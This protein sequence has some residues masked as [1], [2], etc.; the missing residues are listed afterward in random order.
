VAVEAAGSVYALHGGRLLR[1]DPSGRISPVA[2]GFASPLGLAAGPDGEIYVADTGN[3]V[4]RR[5]NV[6]AGTTEI[7][8]RDLGYVVS[9]AGAPDGTIWSSSVAD[10]GRPG[11]WR[12]T[13]GRRSTR[14]LAREVSA[15]TVDRDSAV[16]VC[17]FRERRIL[18]IDVKTGRAETVL[19]AG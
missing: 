6:R 11:V 15:V 12:T 18:R 8:A 10:G 19:R 4:V 5:V 17:A 16:Y 7:V 14:V 9:V 3:G 2:D 13:P 1:R